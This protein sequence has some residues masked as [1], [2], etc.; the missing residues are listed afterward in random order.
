MLRCRGIQLRHLLFRRQRRIKPNGRIPNLRSTPKSRNGSKLDYGSARPIDQPIGS[1]QIRKGKIRKQPAQF[2]VGTLQP[3]I[4]FEFPGPRQFADHGLPGIEIARMNVRNHVF[5]LLLGP[6]ADQP[7][8]KQPEISAAGED[9]VPSADL[10]GTYR[11]LLDPH[12]F[13]ADNTRHGTA[14]GRDAA[15]RVMRRKHRTIDLDPALPDNLESPGFAAADR[16]SPVR[17]NTAPVF[18]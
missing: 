4:G 18:R 8:G 13:M 3:H 6:F 2:P 7:I 9:D 14:V 16:K 1:G 15:V 5:G 11:E 17:G 12:T 10:L